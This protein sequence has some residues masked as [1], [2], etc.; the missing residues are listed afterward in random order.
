MSFLYRSV[1]G[2]LDRSQWNGEAVV[3]FDSAPVDEG[4]P[5]NK[6]FRLHTLA[7]SAEPRPPAITPADLR[8]GVI[9]V[10]PDKEDAVN[11]E[12]VLDIQKRFVHAHYKYIA[13]PSRSHITVDPFSVRKKTHPDLFRTLNLLRNM[14]WALSSPLADKLSEARLGLPLLLLLPGP[15]VNDIAPQ[16]PELRKHCLIACIARTLD[17][18]LEAGIHPD[19]VVQ[20]D[21][22]Q[23]Q[24]HFYDAIPALPET[25]LV[26]L[27][28][29]PFHGYARKFRGVIMMDSFNLELLP[30]PSRLRE[31]YVSSLTACLGLAE[32]LGSP[33]AFVA[34][35]NLSF[36]P[37]PHAQGVWGC[38]TSPIRLIEDS[39]T[40][41]LSD[42]CGAL[43]ESR[44][45]YIATATEADM[46]A[47]AIA[48][49]AGTRFFSTTDGTLLSRK[50]FPH[51]PPRQIF[52]LPT[53]D[54]AAFL[55]DMDN[56]LA[57]REEVDIAKTRLYLL[58]QLEEVRAA[59]R[60]LAEGGPLSGDDPFVGMVKTLRDAPP[61]PETDIRGVAVRLHVAWRKA[62]NNARLLVQGITLAER[63]KALP[64]LCFPKEIEAATSTLG[65]LI[66]KAKWEVYH[67]ATGATPIPAGRQTVAHSGLLAWL[68]NRQVVFASARVLERFSHILE[69]SPNE[70]LFDSR[71]LFDQP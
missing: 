22:F 28:L 30:N 17:I 24:R 61:G 21:T 71:L 70:N 35:A 36:P 50:W 2:G 32:A 57:R 13:F 41:L 12:A 33:Q 62:L 42:R 47:E 44:D 16:L 6:V 27:S 58:S 1:V 31:S 69:L 10:L 5:G 39:R 18:C 48:G 60:Q 23:V 20:L 26:A 65:R 3:V 54:R 14:P 51:T 64:L 34:G 19:F 56:V 7:P 43:V 52:S 9:F 8:D 37:A 46:F 68:D 4:V 67:I 55:R 40:Y 63:G 29:T 11:P 53:I 38:A 49:T 66:P 45:W 15:S 25:V 59:E